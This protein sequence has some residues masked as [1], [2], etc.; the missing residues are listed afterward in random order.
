MQ[1]GLFAPG[2]RCHVAIMKKS[3]GLL[4]K[5][6]TG[7]K[8]LESRWYMSRY[9]PWGKINTGDAVYFK[10]SGEPVTV[11]V[12]VARVL[13]YENLTP[14]KVGGI[15]QKYGTADGLGIET[16]DFEKF[17]ALFKNKRYCL[18]IFLRDAGEVGPF[19]IDKTGFGAMAGWLTF[20]NMEDL[21]KRKLPVKT[22]LPFSYVRP[23]M[24]SATA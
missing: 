24:H 17:Y 4:P 12:L 16:G 15:L 1:T 5:I 11:K 9:A 14:E 18:L 23:S 2:K 7:K 19:N 21:E 10:N 22:Q 20:E 6:L 3:W 13:A 8:K